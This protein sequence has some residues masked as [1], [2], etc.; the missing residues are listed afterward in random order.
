VQLV[1]RNRRQS[2]S[3]SAPH[4]PL[5]GRVRV[6]ATL[7]L[8]VVGQLAPLAHVAWGDHLPADHHDA[9]ITA[10][11]LLCENTAARTDEAPLASAGS[12]CVACSHAG[13]L[14]AVPSARIV[15]GARLGSLL[16]RAPPVH[17]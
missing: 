15:A 11:C 9:A 10:D 16:A 1:S 17:V 4:R 8:F 7:A 5:N 13:T 12:A 14:V 3:I 2:Q 6:L